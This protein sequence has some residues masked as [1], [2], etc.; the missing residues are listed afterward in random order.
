MQRLQVYRL[1]TVTYG[2]AS[3]PFQAIRCLRQLAQDGKERF[4]KGSKILSDHSYVDDNFGGEDSLEEALDAR[5]QLTGLLRTAGM[6]LDKWSANDPRL[7]QDLS[8]TT[9]NERSLEETEVVSTLGLQWLP[10]QDSF[11]FKVSLKDPPRNITK[12]VM[13]SEIASLF[14][15]MR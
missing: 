5:D 2:T 3:A 10:S 12:R 7:L 6:E 9:T 8:D 11:S 4:P 13:L 1:F 14:D 15:P